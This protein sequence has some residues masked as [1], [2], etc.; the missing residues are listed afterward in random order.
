MEWKKILKMPVPIGTRENRDED[1]RQAIIQYEKEVIAPAL[2][3]WVQGA[4]ADENKGLIIR[5]GRAFNEDS[6]S[7]YLYEIGRDNINKFGGN[8]V[9]ILQVIKEVYEQEG[10]QA[11]LLGQH[12]QSSLTIK[13]DNIKEDI[14]Y[15]LP[16]SYN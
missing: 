12:G 9:F 1:Y 7:G 13:Q 16:S 4:E 15:N 5:F 2:S 6:S 10:Y 11:E 3:K 14:N 8:Y